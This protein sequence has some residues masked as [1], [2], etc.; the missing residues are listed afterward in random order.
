[1]SDQVR[2]GDSSGN[3]GAPLRRR[4]R[5]LEAVLGRLER[6]LGALPVPER[7][8]TDETGGSVSPLGVMR[9]P[10]GERVVGVVVDAG[11]AL[12]P[13]RQGKAPA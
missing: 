8:L 7:T 1:M 2:A 4:W 5:P 13:V 10:D 6:L 12:G 11:P 9:G 3:P